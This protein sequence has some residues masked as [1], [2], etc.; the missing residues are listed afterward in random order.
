MSL[1]MRSILA[2]S[3]GVLLFQGSSLANPLDMRKKADGAAHRGILSPTAETLGAGEVA[4]SSIELLFF[5]ASYGISD[6]S[7][8]SLTSWIPLFGEQPFFGIVSFKQKV[9]SSPNLQIS[10]MPNTTILAADGGAAGFVGFQVIADY[11]LDSEGKYVLSF[12]DNNQFAWGGGEIVTDVFFVNASLGFSARFSPKLA[13]MLEAQVPALG[14]S[15]GDS[16]EFTDPSLA[17]GMYGLRYVG[18]G[19]SVDVSFIR[20]LGDG[21]SLTPLGFPFVAATAKF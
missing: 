9:L 4:L 10:I 12:S 19:T 1:S 2:A 8:I 20:I 15:D 17:L 6:S 3:F 5:N 21:E 11:A 18:E 7:Q 14:A 16:T 13:L